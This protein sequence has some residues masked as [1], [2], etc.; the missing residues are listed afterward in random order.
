MGYTRDC[1]RPMPYEILPLRAIAF[2]SLFLM[3]A[4]VLEALVLWRVL[5]ASENWQRKTCIQYAATVNLLS[6]WVG[7][8]VFFIAEPLLPSDWHSAL[9]GYVFFDFKSIPPTL[10]GVGLIIFLATFLLKWQG[11][12]WLE[13][14]L[15]GKPTPPP[16]S[17]DVI[18]FKGRNERETFTIVASRPLAVLWANA[19]SFSAI[20]LLLAIRMMWSN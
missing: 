6:T 19:S 8:M 12:E 7:W 20:T 10:I 13:L 3:V 14:L 16:D 9:I 11:I 1:L 5:G 2:Q 18:K 17:P 4:I 15:K